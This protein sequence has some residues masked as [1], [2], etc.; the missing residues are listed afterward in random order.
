MGETYCPFDQSRM[1][2]AKCLTDTVGGSVAA[3][4][5]SDGLNA[6]RER[7]VGLAVNA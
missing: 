2:P 6:S 3:A 1:T 5:A 4:A 7:Y